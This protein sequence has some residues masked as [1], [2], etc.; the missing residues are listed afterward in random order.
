MF[1]FDSTTYIF[2][3]FRTTTT[4]G[5]RVVVIRFFFRESLLVTRSRRFL[6]RR[7]RPTTTTIGRSCSFF[8]VFFLHDHL[9]LK[10]WMLYCRDAA[11]IFFLF[12]VDTFS[13]TKKLGT[14]D[15]CRWRQKGS[16]EQGCIERQKMVA[17]NLYPTELEDN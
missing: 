11:I 14:C 15:L 4:F 3:S 16:V 2:T 5:G 7:R 17:G 1:V 12:D 10:L 13:R 6:F 8:Y 9:S